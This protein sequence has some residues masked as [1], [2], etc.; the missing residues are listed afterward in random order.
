MSRRGRPTAPSDCRHRPGPTRPSGPQAPARRRRQVQPTSWEL[1]GNDAGQRDARGDRRDV[2]G[3]R[4]PRARAHRTDRRVPPGRALRAHLRPR[5]RHDRADRPVLLRPAVPDAPGRG[6]SG[7]PVRRHART[8]PRTSTGET[9]AQPGAVSGTIGGGEIAAAKMLVVSDEEPSVVTM[10][11]IA[12]KAGAG[13][14]WLRQEQA[15]RPRI[16]RLNEAM[17]W[18]FEHRF[19]Q[20]LRSIKRGN[21]TDW[22]D[23]AVGQGHSSGSYTK[24]PDDWTASIYDQAWTYRALQQLAELNQM[25]GQHDIAEHQLSRARLLRQSVAERFWQ[26]DRGYFRTRILLPPLPREI[27]EDSIVSIANGVAVYAGITDPERAKAG[28]L[29]A[30][31]RTR[32]GGRAEAGPDALAAVSRSA[33]STIRRWSQAGTRTA[34]SGTGGAAC[35]SAASS[36]PATRRWRAT[37]STWWRGTGRASPARST[38]GRR[39][40]RG[41]NPGSPAYAGAASTMAEAIIT[42]LFGVELGPDAWALTP[43]LGAQSGGIHTFHPPSG[44]VLDYWHTYAGDKI[45][46]EWETTHP[47]PGTIRVVLPKNVRVDS[48]LLDQQ[49][50]RMRLEAL[51]DDVIAVLVCASASRQAPAG[52]G[53]GR[54][55]GVTGTP[56]ASLLAV[57]RNVLTGREDVESLVTSLDSPLLTRASDRL[58]PLAAP[59]PGCASARASAT[60]ALS[61]ATRCCGRCLATARAGSS[62]P[63]TWSRGRTRRPRRSGCS[64]RCWAP[65]AWPLP[66]R[67]WRRSSG[68]A[69]GTGICGARRP[70]TRATGSDLTVMTF[71][72]LAWQRE[73]RDLEASIANAEPGHRRVAGDRAA[74]RRAPGRAFSGSTT[75]TTT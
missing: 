21:T 29:G 11:Y 75:R 36:G 74:R 73:G 64:G 8:T 61:S 4:G 39:P 69:G 28:L 1:A 66:A 55:E 62:L 71:N 38:S 68:C 57:R 25:V 65:A 3:R 6:V 2:Q 33:S 14:A 47:N 53:A 45:A 15:G 27:D 42:G 41:K 67:R 35:R 20:Q 44:C 30:G 49:P 7:A 23:V 56:L 12:A 50:V 18:I 22:G 72:T 54:G 9:P 37:T 58:A 31:A 70:A 51:G 10:A 43:R 59:A 60:L 24:E 40:G 46:L 52:A 34:R 63:T 26:P 5:Q 13:A 32:P 16:Q 19:D 48:A 17:D